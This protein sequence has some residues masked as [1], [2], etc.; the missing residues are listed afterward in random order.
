MALYPLPGLGAP[1]PPPDGAPHPVTFL[2][3]PVDITDLI[4]ILQ[5]LAAA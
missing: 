4:A 2:C 3:K 1:I 5:A